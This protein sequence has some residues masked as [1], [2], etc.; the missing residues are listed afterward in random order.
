MFLETCVC[1]AVRHDCVFAP[2][3]SVRPSLWPGFC[4]FSHGALLPAARRYALQQLKVGLL[5]VASRFDVSP[6]AATPA[7]PPDF[8]A[9]RGIVLALRHDCRLRLTPREGA[10]CSQM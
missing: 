3:H 5:A 9:G 2:S 4:P 10:A 7:L 8:L 6:C 1:D